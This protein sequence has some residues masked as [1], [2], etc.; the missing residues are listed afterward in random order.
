MS[1]ERQL[2][3][4]RAIVTHYV[5]TREPVSSKVVADNSDLTVSSATIRGEMVVLENEGLI[6]QPHTSAGRV[7]TEAGYR[8]FVDQ[9]QQLEPLSRPQKD[10][11][12]RFLSEAVDFT[13]VIGRTVR[14]LAQLTQMAAV[15]EY[16]AIGVA[17][18]RRVEVV[19]LGAR[20]VVV[21][22]VTSAGQVDERRVDVPEPPT[23]DQIDA[24]RERLNG[25]AE[26]LTGAEISADAD[27]IE[28]EFAP[29][30]RPLARVVL[31]AMTDILG[32]HG[33][34]RLVVAGLPNLARV[35]S[36]FENVSA[37]LD[38]LE[39]QVA[40]LRL[41]SD[42]QPDS[43]Q[44]AIGGEIGEESLGQAA[45]VSTTYRPGSSGLAHLGVVGPTRMDYHRSLVA[46]EAVSRYLSRL[47]LS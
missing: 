29:P 14:L 25:R 33:S 39:E 47:L 45:I 6:R 5:E 21:V 40:L 37:V 31:Q 12:E 17:S 44:V 34:S 13:D 28:Q 35:G 46:V 11:I 32:E 1:R 8:T 9:L 41:L 2:E 23:P 18:L 4:L 19:P 30:D 20:W 36:D 26:G 27:S 10:A 24:L 7:P 22:V 16:P 38:A 3:V 42:V 43:L 15:V